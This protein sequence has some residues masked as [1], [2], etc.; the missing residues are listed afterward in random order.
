ML[1][2]IEND[3]I[4]VTV[5]DMG[6]EMLSLRSKENGFEYLW[7]GD[8]A[9]WIGHA[10]NLFPICGRLTNSCYT[11]AGK[12]YEM[13]LHGFA[14]KSLFKL[15]EKTDK[16]V[17]FVLTANSITKEQ[18]PFDFELVL[19]YTLRSRSVTTT[20]EVTNQSRGELIF[21]VGGH[22]GFNLPMD[23]N[24]CFEDY[25]IEFPK[26]SAAKKLIL[27]AACFMTDK[28]EPF[29][30]MS[31]KRF[32][33][34]HE[35][36]DNDAIFLCDM[37]KEVTLKSDKSDRSV[38]LKYPDMNYLGFWHVPKKQAPYVCIEPWYS[39]PSYDS[40]VDAFERKR[41]MIHLP[42]AEKYTNSFSITVK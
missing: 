2:T 9:F 41:D 37:P 34:S 24:T 31:A 1:Y 3:R 39:V 19:R 14:R 42:R 36:F 4:S 21:A 13:N 8:P 38:T 27:S 20:F 28:T 11:Y 25:Y 18:Y 12:T 26:R 22:P 30:L 40:E 35:L 6:A 15:L 29:P 5:T 23:E 7:Q 10:Y 33:L 32:S 17:A 16:S